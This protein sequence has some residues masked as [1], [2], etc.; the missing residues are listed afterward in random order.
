MSENI[1]VVSRHMHREEIDLWSEHS[2]IDSEMRDTCG[3]SGRLLIGLN[4]YLFVNRKGVGRYKAA[5]KLRS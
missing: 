5:Q 1:V 4:W 2:F 3:L